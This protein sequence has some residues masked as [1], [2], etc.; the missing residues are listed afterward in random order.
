MTP[1]WRESR[2][3]VEF[4]AAPAAAEARGYRE[5]RLHE[6]EQGTAPQ[7]ARASSGR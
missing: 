5:R 4:F 6:R 7:H 3:N 1:A 2:A